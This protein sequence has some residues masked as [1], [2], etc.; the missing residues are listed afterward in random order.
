MMCC[1]S[2]LCVNVLSMLWVKYKLSFFKVWLGTQLIKFS[3]LL[4][5]LNVNFANK[6]MNK[7]YYIFNRISHFCKGLLPQTLLQMV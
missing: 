4:T 3:I 7:Q 5:F 6:S 2:D 1:F